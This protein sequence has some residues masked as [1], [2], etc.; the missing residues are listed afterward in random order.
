MKLELR[1]RAVFRELYDL[2][3]AFLFKV[4]EAI[5]QTPCD[6]FGWTAKGR[7]IVVE[8]K[9]VNRASLPIGTSNGLAP[10]QWL[11]LRQAAACGAHSYLVWQRGDVIMVLDFGTC[12]RLTENR[13]SIPFWDAAGYQTHSLID[14]FSRLLQS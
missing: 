4:P 9:Q 14:C 5:Q 3:V 2:Q 6:F 10:H 1:L 12:L 11:A 13:K 8:A 7:A